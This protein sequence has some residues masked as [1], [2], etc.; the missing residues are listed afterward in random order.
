MGVLNDVT[1]LVENNQR[2]E[3]SERTIRLL[4]DSTA[5][6][7]YGVD[8]EGCC[9]FCNAACVRLLGFE[10][11]DQLV[12]Q[13]IHELIHHHRS[14]GSRYPAHDCGVYQSLWSGLP[15]NNDTDVFWKADGTCFPVEYWSHPVKTDGRVTGVVVTFFDTTLRRQ[16]QEALRQAQENAEAASEAKSRFLANMSHELRT[17]LAAILGFT[18]IIQ[19][20]HSDGELLEKVATI[21]RNGDY[22]L[23]LLNDVL[24]LSRIE[25]GKFTVM[26]S[27]VRTDELIADLR[28][29]MDMRRSEYGTSLEFHLEGELPHLIT[30]DFSRLRQVLVNLIGNAIKF[31]SGGAVSAT[32]RSWRGDH[33]DAIGGQSTLSVIVTMTGS[34]SLKSNLRFCSSRFRKLIQRSSIA[35]VVPGWG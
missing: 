31:A 23:R 25:A 6:G 19:E 1:E 27:Q 28:E 3:E 32:F 22:L 24:D 33:P 8:H 12:G 26:P 5:E 18:K 4:L 16:E 10:S 2:A 13:N 11:A 35:S 34:V 29:T 17:P 15:T 21:Q 14:D 30:T 20:E 9:T 7:I